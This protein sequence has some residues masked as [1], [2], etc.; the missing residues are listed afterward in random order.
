MSLCKGHS[1]TIKTISGR[2]IKTANLD[3]F[4]ARNMDS[5]SVVGLSMAIIENGKIAYSKNCGFKNNKT[6][7]QV[8]DSTLFEA[9]S[10]SKPVFAFFVLK[11]VEKGIFDLDK[12][13]YL[14]YQDPKVDT[15]KGYYKLLTARMV[16][17]HASGF[18]NW[19]ENEDFTKTLYFE[20]KPGTKYGYSGEGY[21]YLAM[22]ISK[23]MKISEQ[24]LNDLFN[25]MVV[26]PLQLSSMNFTW[27]DKLAKYKAYSHQDGQ[28][29]D[30]GSQ[31]P[32][33]WF[34]SAG[35][36]HTN[37]VDYGKFLMY[38]LNKKNWVSNQM[39]TIQKKLPPLEDSMHRALGFPYKKINGKT[40]FY[41]SGNNGDT[42]SYLHFYPKEKL[43]IVMFSNCDTF[44]KSNFAEIL[45]KYFDEIMTD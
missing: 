22:A 16:L 13:L 23:K 32:K 33:N 45:L 20:N 17:C 38:N 11:L 31:G 5:L 6:K 28:P 39:L 9:C 18:Q 37:A 44:F 25:N 14:Y 2:K 43:G 29:T 27:N 26:K 40:R 35:S 42:R 41:H 10:L 36:L 12:P 19:R 4:I 3:A 34:G 15:A 1:Q 24:G 7:E 30:N 21:Q 8:N